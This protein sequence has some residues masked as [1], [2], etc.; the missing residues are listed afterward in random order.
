MNSQTQS[1]MLNSR[2]RSVNTD[3]FRVWTHEMAYVQGYTWADGSLT[4]KQVGFECKISDREILESIKRV[5]RSKHTI[6]IRGAREIFDGKYE[7]GEIATLQVCGHELV[8]PLFEMGMKSGKSKKYDLEFP[9]GIP[10][11]FLGSFCRG[12][13]DGDGSVITSRGQAYVKFNGTPK[14]IRGLRDALVHCVGVSWKEETQPSRS[15]KIR[16]VTWGAKRDI[17]LLYGT[18]YKHVSELSLA[19]KHEILKELCDG[20]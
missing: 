13:L 16:R 11:E 2:N 8:Q 4:Q 20:A 5:M 18:L 19:R 15:S 7:S 3:F 14:F 10:P 1:R 9:T 12:Y 6:S 17:R